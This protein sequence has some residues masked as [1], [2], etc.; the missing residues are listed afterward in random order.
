MGV[1]GTDNFQTLQHSHPQPHHTMAQTESPIVVP[2]QT[3]LSLTKGEVTILRAHLQDWK[4]VKGKE[5]TL[6]LKAIHK[7]ASL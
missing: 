1:I 4:S 2:Q 5:R 7:E 3:R 6:V